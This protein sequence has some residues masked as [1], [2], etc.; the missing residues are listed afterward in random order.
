[1]EFSAGDLG[2]CALIQRFLYNSSL[3]CK[4]LQ[5]SGIRAINRDHKD[6]EKMHISL[7]VLLWTLSLETLM[8]VR[9]I[10]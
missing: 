7:P 6:S 9:K 5:S 8:Y 1:M 2:Y 10:N 3:L 4:S